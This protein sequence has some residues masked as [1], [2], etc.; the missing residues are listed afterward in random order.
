MYKELM[1]IGDWTFM[2]VPHDV[3]DRMYVS[4]NCPNNKS[5]MRGGNITYCH[6][7]KLAVPDEVHCLLRLY[8]ADH[9][10]EGDWADDE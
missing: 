3:G 8:N 4:H 7:C 2:L 10:Y 9:P 5:H 6:A 1:T